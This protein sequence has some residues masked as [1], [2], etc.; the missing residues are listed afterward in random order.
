MCNLDLYC[1]RLSDISDSRI[2]FAVLN[3]SAMWP[4]Q[5]CT[6]VDSDIGRCWFSLQAD[7]SPGLYAIIFAQWLPHGSG[8]PDLE[9][10]VIHRLPI[11]RHWRNYKEAELLVLFKEM[12][13]IYNCVAVQIIDGQQIRNRLIGLFAKDLKDIA[14]KHGNGG[15]VPGQP[16]SQHTGIQRGSGLPHGRFA[17]AIRNLNPQIM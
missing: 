8:R 4:Q 10:G 14:F 13:R 16:N 5:V 15:I 7:D 6:Y 12:F 2:G 1:S 17:L 3:L 9:A 11:I